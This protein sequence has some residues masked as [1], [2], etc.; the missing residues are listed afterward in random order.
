MRILV[1]QTIVIAAQ[2]MLIFNL[3]T[4]LQQTHLTRKLFESIP[5]LQCVSADLD[6]E[7]RDVVD[8]KN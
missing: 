3:P 1:Y 7:L 8:V 4:V 2:L 5:L 6:L